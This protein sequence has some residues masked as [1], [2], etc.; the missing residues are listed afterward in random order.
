MY[1][2]RHLSWEYNNDTDILNIYKDDVSL[3]SIPFSINNQTLRIFTCDM[4][5]LSGWCRKSVLGTN[6]SFRDFCLAGPPHSYPDLNRIGIT[7]GE[8]YKR[9]QNAKIIKKLPKSKTI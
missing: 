9:L 2:Y 3:L 4:C 7:G 1:R 8:F 5:E 6:K